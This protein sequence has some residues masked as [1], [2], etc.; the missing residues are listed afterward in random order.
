[1]TSGRLVGVGGTAPAGAVL[2]VL[3]EL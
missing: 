3:Q 1:V 2:R